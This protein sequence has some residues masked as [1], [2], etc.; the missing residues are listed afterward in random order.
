MVHLLVDGDGWPGRLDPEVFHTVLQARLSAPADVHARPLEAQWHQ[1]L[2]QGP[3]VVFLLLTRALEPGWSDGVHDWLADSQHLLYVMYLDGIG[4][5]DLRELAGLTAAQSVARAPYRIAQQN[6]VGLERAAAWV[7]DILTRLAEKEVAVPAGPPPLKVTPSRWRNLPSNRQDAFAYPDQISQAQEGVGGYRMIGA[8]LRGKTH[9][10]HG[11]FRDD[12]F[13]LAATPHWS[14]LAVADG[15][16]TAPLARV[17]S[18]LAATRAAEAARVA[19]PAAPSPEDL[20]R[21]IWAGLKAAYQAIRDFASEQDVP[22]SDLHTTLQLLIHWPRD[23]GCL[24]GVAQ[25]G[26][27][28]IVAEDVDGAFYPPLAEPDTDPEDSGRTLFLTSGPLRG[29]MAR[30][31]VYQFEKP[32][33]VVALMTDGLAT[34]ME[35]YAERLP[36]ALFEVLRQRVLCYPLHQREQPLLAYLSYDRRGSFDDRT[37]AILSNE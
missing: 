12:A 11:T 4:D 31:K 10:H 15:A 33:S 8:S 25:I 27:G 30:A 16:G 26:D 1:H 6:G 17:G 23:E 7:A 9:A 20:G 14:I 21:A 3:A 13:A 37:L 2:P 5:A 18:N 29:W 34:D 35:P 19:A 36:T 24:V 22:M 32:L 28:I